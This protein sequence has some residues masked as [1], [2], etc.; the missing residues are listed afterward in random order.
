MERYMVS[1]RPPLRFW[2][3][4]CL[5]VSRAETGGAYTVHSKGR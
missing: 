5:F 4:T 1:R 2:P 3:V